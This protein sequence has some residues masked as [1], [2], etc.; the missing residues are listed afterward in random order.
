MLFT[1]ET[2]RVLLAACIVGMALLALLSMRRR[3]LTS[4]EII[5]WG[6]LIILVPL[7]GPFLVIV[8]KPG[9]KRRRSLRRYPFLGRKL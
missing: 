7:L 4:A 6:L 9:V 2:M 1:P 3:N 8:I 5:G